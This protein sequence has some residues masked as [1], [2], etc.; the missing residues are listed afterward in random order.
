MAERAPHTE[1]THVN[2]QNTSKL[3]THHQRENV[4]ASNTDNTTKFAKA[5]QVV[6]MTIDMHMTDMIDAVMT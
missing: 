2:R 1:R 3:R 6:Q 5:L 4:C